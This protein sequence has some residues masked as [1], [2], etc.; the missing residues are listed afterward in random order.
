MSEDAVKAFLEKVNS[1]EAFYKKLHSAA[2]DESILSIAK[3]A[4]FYLTPGLAKGFYVKYVKPDDLSE[5]ELEEMA[6]GGGYT[7]QPEGHYSVGDDGKAFWC[8]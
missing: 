5:K 3:E 4:G 2:D 7:G 8:P 1:D 6:G